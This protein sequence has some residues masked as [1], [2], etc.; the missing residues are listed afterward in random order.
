MKCFTLGV[1][2]KRLFESDEHIEQPSFSEDGRHSFTSEEA[3]NIIE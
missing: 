2:D 1:E 3:R